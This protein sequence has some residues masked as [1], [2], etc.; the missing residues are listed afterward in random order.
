MGGCKGAK[1]VDTSPGHTAGLRPG[2]GRP[3]RRFRPLRPPPL[4]FL[5]PPHPSPAPS[6]PAHARAAPPRREEGR[7]AEGGQRGPLGGEGTTRTAPPKPCRSNVRHRPIHSPQPAR[8]AD[9]EP[10]ERRGVVWRGLVP[11]PPGS[12]TPRGPGRGAALRAARVRR[13]GCSGA[14]LGEG[15]D[16]EARGTAAR[17]AA[18]GRPS[19]VPKGPKF[20]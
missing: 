18:R 11:A 8:P 1:Q 5:P 15:V 16:A 4:A 14:G 3:A 19:P 2:T 13:A 12:P 9:F 7:T 6:F 20:K 10:G 17:A